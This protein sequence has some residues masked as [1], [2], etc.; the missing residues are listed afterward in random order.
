MQGI[1]IFL[2]RGNKMRL[3]RM[4]HLSLMVL[5]ALLACSS[6]EKEFE[7]AKA[8]ST[9]KAYEE[10]LQKYPDTPFKAEIMDSIRSLDFKNAVRINTIE[11][12][13][14]FMEKYRDSEFVE[15][16]ENKIK[17]LTGNII[18]RL[19][20]EQLTEEKSRELMQN[21]KLIL[22]E[23]PEDK[24][25]PEGPVV[26]SINR[27]KVE[28]IG[29]LKA[30]PSAITDS[31]G[32]FTLSKVP[33][34]TYLILFHLWPSELKSIGANWNDTILTEACLDRSG[35]KIFASGESDFWKEGGLAVV[36]MN[37]D[38]QKG[39]TATEGNV[40]SNSLGFCFSVRDQRPHPIIKVQPGSTVQ[41]VIT[42][43]IKPNEEKL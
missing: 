27:N 22:C 12:Y 2:R 3:E 29:T 38:V 21:V 34:G 11:A 13:E 36:R 23:I 35:E 26:A 17:S 14:N 16:A 24:G 41:I 7:E 40:C 10:Y 5:F 25:L 42:T 39:F 6:P 30:E 15:Q 9:I 37:W 31:D 19:V 43:H 18:G 8:E 32:N 28:R 33:P 1:R 4:F 20:F